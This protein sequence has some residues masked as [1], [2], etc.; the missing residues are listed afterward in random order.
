MFDCDIFG[1]CPHHYRPYMSGAGF[2]FRD[3]IETII[4]SQAARSSSLSF[5][6]INMAVVLSHRFQL[7]FV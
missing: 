7:F 3:I 4:H 6:K 1:L 2:Y 5:S